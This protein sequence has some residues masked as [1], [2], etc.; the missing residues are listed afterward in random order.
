MM[1]SEAI[2]RLDP[3]PQILTRE[4]DHLAAWRIKIVSA[5][6]RPAALTALLLLL[7]ASSALAEPVASVRICSIGGSTCG[8]VDTNGL[9]VQGAGVAGTPAGGVVSIQGVASGTVVP[10]TVGTA[11]TSLGKAEDV[12]AA[13]GD[14]GVAM[15]GIIN[16]DNN[17]SAP[18]GGADEDYTWMAV[19]GAGHPLVAGVIAHSSAAAGNPLLLGAHVEAYAAAMDSSGVADADVTRLKADEEGRMYVRTDHA[20]RFQCKAG[21]V[22]ARTQ[23]Q[24]APG[25]GSLY[26]TDMIVS[27]NAA[28]NFKLEQGTGTNCA[29]SP[30]D[31]TDPFYF[32][33]N[34]G[35]P[36]DF[37]TPL[38]VDAT[39]AVCCTPSAASGTCLLLGY[40]AP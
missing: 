33:A 17:T 6:G 13:S 38:K 35:F 32:N 25:S 12:A 34:G 27:M 19:D 18:Y 1:R 26:I 36:K 14:T 28:G 40:T 11:A 30:T 29:T 20:N 24:A 10:V 22:S 4:A 39:K 23:C 3:R 37:S 31:L 15:L 8:S 2:I 5:N 9:E 7:L 21:A 16:P